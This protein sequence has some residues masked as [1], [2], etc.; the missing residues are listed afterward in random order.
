MANMLDYLEEVRDTS[1]AELP[2][3]E[4]DALLFCQLTYWPFLGVIS[5]QGTRKALGE[6]IQDPAL[7][8]SPAQKH[9][10]VHDL[11]YGLLEKMGKSRRFG[12]VLLSDCVDSAR[13]GEDVQ[14]SALAWHFGEESTLVTFRGTE[15]TLKSWQESATMSY[16]PVAKS[17]EMAAIYLAER[18][19]HFNEKLYLGGH[20]KGGNLALYAA[21]QAQESLRRR[22]QFIYN[23]DGPGFNESVRLDAPL[24]ALNPR[25][26]TYVPQSSLVGMLLCHEEPAVVIK[27]RAVAI[28]QHATYSW[29]VED[30]HLVRLGELSPMGQF[31]RRVMKR[32]LSA[33]SAE[34]KAE[35]IDNVAA[36]LQGS[37]EE[38]GFLQRMTRARSVLQTM[39]PEEQE[40]LKKTLVAFKDAFFE[41]DE[42]QK[43]V[44]RRIA[45]MFQNL[46]KVIQKPLHRDSLR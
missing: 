46:K 2:F 7:W 24:R 5:A 20:S 37:D 8:Q 42:A 38:V 39:D 13:N 36:I 31:H 21:V 40:I 33:L 28:F 6:A 41:G 26:R 45:G 30:H 44:G 25:I 15:P 27:S 10:A 4:V 29:Q 3:N 18:G 34:E 23:M 32:W 9:A 14:F 17:Q 43:E 35:F 11:D 19:D 12:G 1:M 22:L 16:L